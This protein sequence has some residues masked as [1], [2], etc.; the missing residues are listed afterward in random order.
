LRS[1]PAH[2][3]NAGPC[4]HCAARESSQRRRGSIDSLAAGDVIAFHDSLQ[5]PGQ[6]YDQRGMDMIVAE[7]V[8]YL[9][10]GGR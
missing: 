5:V 2:F 6:A 10:D 1:S 3:G 7:E 8:P 4:W 9:T